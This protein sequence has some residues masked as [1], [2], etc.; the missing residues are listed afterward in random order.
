MESFNY[1]SQLNRAGATGNN[2][3]LTHIYGELIMTGTIRCSRCETAIK[4]EGACPKC[5]GIRCYILLYWKRSSPYKIRRDRKTGE[6]LQYIKALDVLLEINRLIRKKAFNIYDWVTSKTNET[7]LSNKLDE[8][9]KAKEDQVQTGEFSP[10]TLKNYKGYVE[11]YYKKFKIDSAGNGC[12]AEEAEESGLLGHWNVAEIRKP[13]IMKFKKELMKITGLKLKTKKNVLN[14][15]H[16]FFTWLATEDPAEVMTLKDMPDFPKI[17]GDDAEPRKVIDFDTQAD[18]IKNI[19]EKHRDIIEFG[20]ELFL[21]PGETCALKIKDIDFE[22][23]VVIIRRTWSGSTLKEN[24][25]A[26]KWKTKPLTDRAYEIALRNVHNRFPEE[27]LFINPDTKRC[28]RQKILNNI[29]KTYSG[30]DTVHYEGSRHSSLTQL[31]EAGYDITAIKELAGH[32]DIRTT[33]KYIHRSLGKLRE[34]ANN[35]K[36]KLYPLSIQKENEV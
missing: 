13:E 1:P 20:C 25:K 33:Q 28:Y 15:L 17:T 30:T 4:S 36:G 11:N 6:P 22:N 2:V 31:A 26:K 32:T 3:L 24:T 14:G 19:P 9:L 27:F 29:W 18:G 8:W 35:R 16:A 5:G 7:K 21:R 10:E 12:W 23:R 34:I